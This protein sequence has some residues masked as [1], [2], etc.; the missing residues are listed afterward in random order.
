MG[1]VNIAEERSLAWFCALVCRMPVIYKG[2]N[3]S[4]ELK[5]TN[6]ARGVVVDMIIN[7][8]IVDGF[9][10]AEVVFVHFPGCKVDL[11]GLPS[12][13]VPITPVSWSFNA[14]VEMTPG[15]LKRHNVTRYQLNLQPAFSFTVHSAQ[16][17]TIEK[18]SVF[19]GKW[20]FC[21]IC[22]GFSSYDKGRHKFDRAS[23]A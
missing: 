8:N 22:N 23:G 15:D 14:L 5:I 7:E 4:T 17:Q 2:R 20:G 9:P 13:V 16:G 11:K 6:G 10:F 21:C 1:C 18:I 3:L 12:E 19:I